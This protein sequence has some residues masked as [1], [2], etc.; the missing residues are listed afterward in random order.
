M[1]ARIAAHLANAGL[2]VVMLDIASKAGAPGIAAQ[3]LE[4]LKRA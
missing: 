4:G 3:A 1:G 2:P